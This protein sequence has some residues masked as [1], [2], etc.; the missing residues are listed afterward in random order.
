[1]CEEK[2]GAVAVACDDGDPDGGRP[3]TA[4]EAKE[5]WENTFRTLPAEARRMRHCCGCQWLKSCG[6]YLCCSHIL[7]TDRKRPCPPGPNCTAKKTPPGWKYPKG[8]A[9]WCAEMDRKHGKKLQQCKT[10]QQSF[11]R[12]Y[13]RQLHD[14]HWH[15]EDI[16]AVVG[17]EV[18]ALRGLIAR[19]NWKHGEKWRATQHRDG[20]TVM[21]ERERY[22]A[23]KAKY[24]Q[25]NGIT[26]ETDETE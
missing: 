24:E 23:A 12:I 26:S 25:E 20:F 9:D 10:K 16:A 11:Q 15:T 4:K 6:A 22:K 13:A 17:M 2:W 19:E 21:L 18:L 3:Q 5:L 8:Y 1:M 14:Q 7:D